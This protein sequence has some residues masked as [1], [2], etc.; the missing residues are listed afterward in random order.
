MFPGSEAA[1]MDE[2]I[3]SLPEASAQDPLAQLVRRIRGGEAEAFEPLMARTEA[4][5]LALAWRILGDRHLAED[6]AQETFLRVFRSLHTYRLGEPFE[7]WMIRIAVN[8]CRDLARK[9]GPLP[10]PLDLLDVLEGDAASLGAEEA[11][12]LQQRRALVRQAL[13]GLPQAERTALVL[14]DLE[15]LS[16]E[17]VARILGVRPVTIRSQ[18]AS[19]RTK[20]QAHCARLTTPPQGGRP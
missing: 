3:A 15:G 14:R 5:I 17:E 16:T 10:V 13:A 4:R 9:R 2:G 7:A 8:V 12:L 18:V 20:L 11:V 19:A 6:A 1:L